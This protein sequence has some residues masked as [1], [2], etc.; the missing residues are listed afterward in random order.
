MSGT[1]EVLG[2]GVDGLLQVYYGSLKSPTPL[3]NGAGQRAMTPSNVDYVLEPSR[4][5]EIWHMFGQ[6]RLVGERGSLGGAASGAD[7]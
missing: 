3:Q 5:Q 1:L 7:M 2:C 6:P 4:P